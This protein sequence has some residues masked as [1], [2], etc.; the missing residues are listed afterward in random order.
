MTSYLN[1]FLLTV[2]SSM[3]IDYRHGKSCNSAWTE[4]DFFI[5][6]SRDEKKIIIICLTDQSAAFNV[7]QVDILIGKLKFLGF[8]S[9]ACSLIANYLHGRQALCKVNGIASPLIQL[10]SGVGE[11]SV[12][13]PSLYTLGQICVSEVIPITKECLLS[14]KGVIMDGISIEYTDNVTGVASGTVFV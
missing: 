11:G 14:E 6:K 2:P 9:S 12:L 4:L 1:E 8:S 7:L 5:Q 3:H 10:D 13:G